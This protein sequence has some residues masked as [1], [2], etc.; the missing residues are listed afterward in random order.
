[1]KKIVTFLLLAI[2]FGSC[3]RQDPKE[4]INYLNGYWEIKKVTKPDGSSKEFGISMLVDFIEIK[5]DSGVRT[6]V[7]PKL[8][9]S[10]VATKAREKFNTKIEG[11]QLILMYATPYDQWQETVLKA[12]DSV[13]EMVNA[14]GNT[15]LYRRYQPF[16]NSPE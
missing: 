3:D 15:Y 13:L 4:Q 6:K 16:N 9:G 5:G 7:S 14:A 2:V 1:M 11:D 10:F 8:D 12:K